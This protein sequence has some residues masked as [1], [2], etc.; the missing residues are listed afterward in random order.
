MN[1]VYYFWEFV[2][3]KKN[4]H[5]RS[6]QSNF[7]L[8]CR[9]CRSTYGRLQGKNPTALN[10]RIF[11]PQHPLS[12]FVSASP[13]NSSGKR[14]NNNETNKDNSLH[15]LRRSP[16]RR[17]LQHR[18]TRAR[19]AG[20]TA[21]HRRSRRLRCLYPWHTGHPRRIRG[22]DGSDGH[23]R[24]RFRRVWICDIGRNRCCSTMECYKDH[25]YSYLHV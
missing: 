9:I 11:N 8:F 19:C 7:F 23:P 3:K 17:L 6:R 2:L 18:R 15:A 22:R 5:S 14:E 1:N 13:Q 4:S 24:S 12:F 20:R 10:I 16:L 25:C 21:D